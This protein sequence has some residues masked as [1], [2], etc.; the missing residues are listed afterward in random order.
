[1]RLRPSKGEGERSK[2]L[3]KK[4]PLIITTALLVGYPV[5]AAQAA[6]SAL[7]LSTQ[8]QQ[9]TQKSSQLQSQPRN[10]LSLRLIASLPSN[11]DLVD[12]QSTLDSYKSQLSILKASK[13]LDPDLDTQIAQEISNAESKIQL[14][15]NKILKLK[16]DLAA[17]QLA[18]NTL[19]SALQRLDSAT[20]KEATAK[21]NLDTATATHTEASTQ[22]ALDA[23]AVLSAQATLEDSKSATLTAKD[24]ATLSQAALE[25]QAAVMTQAQQAVQQQQQASD[26]AQARVDAAQQTLNEATS[27]LQQAS[28]DLDRATVELQT[29]QSKVDSARLIYNQALDH[30]NQTLDTYTTVYNEYLAAQ[31]AQNQ[32]QTT[33]IQTQDTLI[34]AQ[35]NYDN[36]LIPD[37]TWT[38]T[39]QEVAHTRQVPVTTL[40]PVTTTQLTGGLTADSFNR[41]N[42]GGKPPLP[43]SNETPIATQV[44]PNINFQWSGGQVLNS[45]KSDRVLVRF[46][47][48]ISFP[49][50]QDVRFYAPGDDGVQLYIDG[51]L[52]INDWFDKGGGGSQSNY[53]HFEG[54]SSHTLTLYFYENGGGANVWLYYA[55]P[56]TGFQ[57]VPAAYLGTTATTTTTYV[58]QTTYTTETYYTTEVV[59]GQVHPLINDPALL[60]ALEE[61]QQNQQLAL[62]TFNEADQIWKAA[63]AAQQ[64]AARDSLAGYYQVI[65]TATTLNSASSDLD[66][67][68]NTFNQVQSS[69]NQTLQ[70]KQEAQQDLT[71]KKSTLNEESTK[72]QTKKNVLSTETRKSQAAQTSNEVAKQDLTAKQATQASAQDAYDQSVTKSL[73]SSS[74]EAAAK[75]NEDAAVA[76]YVAAQDETSAATSNKTSAEQQLQESESAATTSN[77]EAQGA[78]TIPFSQIKDLLNQEPPKKEEGSAEIPPVIEDLMKVDL[79]AV[80]PTELTPEQA[81]QLVEAALVVFETATEGSAEYEQALDA[82]Y[83]AAEQDDIVIDAALAE[84]PGVGQAAVAIANVLNLVGNVGA[85]ISPK[86]RKK[87]QTLVV[88]TLVIGQIAQTAAL[89]TASSGGSSN[90]TIRRK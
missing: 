31:S 55:T 72:L 87:A 70:T 65:D 32:A 84:I 51:N 2:S 80:D 42:Y 85:D 67:E 12:L 66:V 83:L 63:Q 52:I 16:T 13:P 58:E 8:P 47:G 39:T 23:Q 79:A 21:S 4:G 30:Y 56:I 75:T 18:Q 50:T 68:Q 44:V 78:S 77:E 22:A 26:E 41:Q 90:R 38:P 14:L 89:A 28:T 35:W 27:A 9:E 10:Y 82:L 54:G 62:A 19:T 5:C 64:T 25:N 60:S 49:D 81:T 57:I 69:Y 34:Q 53:L 29:K 7:G 1:M 40:V 71:N 15:T 73:S 11:Q 33:L 88:T 43:A 24:V 46:T 76:N 17:L 20:T 61:A 59:P 3:I 36:N 86:A 74:N 48:N 6:T 37:P 45:G